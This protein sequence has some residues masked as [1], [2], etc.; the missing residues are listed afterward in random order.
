MKQSLEK[1]YGSIT[2]F[3]SDVDNLIN[4]R[5]VKIEN[6][7]HRLYRYENVN[8]ARIKGGKHVGYKFNDVLN[9]K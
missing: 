2:Y 4:S 1:G 9:L 8:T 3:D 7:G 5:F 6:N